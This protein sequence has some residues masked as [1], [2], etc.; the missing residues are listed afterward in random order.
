MK[1]MKD[2]KIKLVLEIMSLAILVDQQ[3]DY[4][5]FVDYSGHIE[6]LDIDVSESKENW[7][8]KIC[9]AGIRAA[10]SNYVDKG[11]ENAYLKSR[12]DVLREI[13]ET[14][15]IPYHEMTEHVE[16]IRKYEF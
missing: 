3:T 11:E 10:F 1:L 9:K 2:E 14:H 15:E 4:C 5:V 12:R 6:S 16:E 7:R 8:N 13:L